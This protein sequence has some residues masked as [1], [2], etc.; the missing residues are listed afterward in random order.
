[1]MNDPSGHG[2]L[3]GNT[4]PVRKDKPENE[5]KPANGVTS[6]NSSTESSES[7]TIVTTE[8]L[9]E[10]KCPGTPGSIAK[11]KIPENIEPDYDAIN[12]A[13][14]QG[15]DFINACNEAAAYNAGYQKPEYTPPRE[16]SI[17]SRN[18]ESVTFQGG[19]SGNGNNSGSKKVNVNKDFN[20]INIQFYK[21]KTYDE[22]GNRILYI[23]QQQADSFN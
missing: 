21:S 2:T 9:N 18:P 23:T 10:P 13:A 16:A 15:M 11:P 19:G 14:Q 7:N 1:M 5:E 3:F 6:A 20:T 4:F 22:N 8:S 17:E 12:Q